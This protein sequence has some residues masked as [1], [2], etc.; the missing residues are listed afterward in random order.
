MKEL[1]KNA[2]QT[3]E[4]LNQIAEERTIINIKL[5]SAIKEDEKQKELDRINME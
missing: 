3:Q 1:E 5:V 2:N 4:I